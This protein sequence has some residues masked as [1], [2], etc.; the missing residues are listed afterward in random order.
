ME[1]YKCDI[2][3]MCGLFRMPLEGKWSDSVTA[4][5][6]TPTKNIQSILL[7][8]L[9]PRE[10]QATYAG[11]MRRPAVYLFAYRVDTKDPYILACLFG[12][13]QDDLAV[14]QVTF[15]SDAYEYLHYDGIFNM[16]IVCSDRSFPSA[17]KYTEHIPPTWIEVMQ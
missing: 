13:D 6:I 12:D 4:Y 15:P 17:I 3:V 7:R 10:C 2:D 9:E 1:K 16:S 8:G 5:H 11:P 14:L